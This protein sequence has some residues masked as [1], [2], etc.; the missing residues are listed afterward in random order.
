[1]TQGLVGYARVST[2]DQ[3][4]QLQLDALHKA[5]CVRVFQETMSG[6]IRERPQLQAALDFLRPGD[7][8]VVWKLD[9]LARSL[10]QLIE[11]VERLDRESCDFLSLTESFINTS[12]AGGRLVFNMFGALAE[13]ERAII[14]ERTLAGLAAARLK[15]RKGGRPRKLTDIDLIA[16]KVLLLDGQLTVAEVAEKLK[17]SIATLYKYIPHPRSG[18]LEQGD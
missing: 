10:P 5:G 13:F 9:R 3:D 12:S 4:P 2:S 11:T 8:L 16:A 14:R 17:V 7:T 1:M 15:G 18:L 6:S